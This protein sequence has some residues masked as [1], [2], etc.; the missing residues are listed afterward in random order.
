MHR[1]YERLGWETWRGPSAVRTA[2]AWCGHP[3]RTAS[4]WS[5]GRRTSPAL[6]PVA[7][8][9]ASGARA[10]SGDA[11]DLSGVR[12]AGGGPVIPER[13]RA[14][15]V[16]PN[17]QDLVRRARQRLPRAHRGRE[18]PHQC[19]RAARADG[20]HD[21]RSSRPTGTSPR[22]GIV[23]PLHGV[24]FTV[25]DSFD[26]AGIVTTA[27]TV[28][29]RDRVPDHDA[30]VVARLAGRRRDPRSA[31]RTRPSSPGPTRP[32]T[33]CTAGHRTPTTSSGRPAAAAGERR[34]S[35]RRAASPFDVGS[36][37]GDSIRQPAHVCGVAGIKPTLG[38]VPRTGSLAG[39]TAGSSRPSRSSGPMAR[40]V[41][42]LALL[43][44]D[45]RRA[46]RC[47]PVRLR[48][49]RLRDPRAVRR[50]ATCAWRRSPTTAS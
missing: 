17:A 40:R 49:C 5:C 18:P 32:T 29:W 50:R 22:V 43:L 2:R 36:D 23:G 4:S 45:H 34:R 26:T 35:W 30:T 12:F 1:F 6:D 13:D 24:P 31:R 37:T 7:P 48:R 44:S 47:G 20:A 33:T 14:R 28:G 21:A 16:A 27:G 41:E 11:G 42:D 39:R 10:T 19:R 38:R 8:I 46:R 25:K 3:T 15:R 9:S